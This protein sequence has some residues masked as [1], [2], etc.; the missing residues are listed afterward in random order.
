ML[1]T[2]RFVIYSLAALL[3]FSTTSTQYPSG[4]RTKAIFLI[5]PSV[6]FFFQLQFMSSN[7]AHAASMLSTEMPTSHHCQ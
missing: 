7:R 1:G 3:S 5:L 4:S 2:N 6:S